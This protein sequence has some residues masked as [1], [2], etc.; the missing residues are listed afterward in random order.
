MKH[1]AA[2]LKFV[3]VMNKCFCLMSLRS[4]ITDPKLSSCHVKDFEFAVKDIE[5][6]C[7]M[8]PSISSPDRSYLKI[9]FKI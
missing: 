7:T 1:N 4:I 3:Q 6:I 2:F 9:L 5:K 8:M